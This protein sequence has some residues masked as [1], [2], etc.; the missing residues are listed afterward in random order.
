MLYVRGNRR[1][2]DSWEQMGNYGWRYDDVLPYFIKSEDNRNPYLAKSSYHGVGGYLTVQDAFI[3]VSS[4][5][6]RRRQGG[7]ELSTNLF[8]KNLFLSSFF[9][10]LKLRQMMIL[11]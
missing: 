11:K 4:C 8:F 10:F 9:S 1:D 3:A 2:Y 5:L 6:Y 7:I